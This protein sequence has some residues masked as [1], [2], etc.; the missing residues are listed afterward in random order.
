MEQVLNFIQITQDVILRPDFASAVILFWIAFVNELIAIFPYTLVLSGQLIFFDGLLSWAFLAKLL[1]FVAVPVALGSTTS[2]LIFYVLAYFGGKPA[3]EKFHNYLHF[4]WSDVEKVSARFKGAWYDEVIFLILR[5]M[6]ILPSLPL[7]V[8]AG[9]L[10]MRFWPY[11]VLTLVGFTIRMMLTLLIVGVGIGDLSQWV[12]F[13][14][15]H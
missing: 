11:F 13:L 4:S 3:I 9:I 12:F 6:P 2:S 5:S 10:R 15:N 1:V 14:Y 8:M 7:D